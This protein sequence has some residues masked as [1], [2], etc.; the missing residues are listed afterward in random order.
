MTHAA[1]APAGPAADYGHIEPIAVYFDD[2]D[3]MGIVHNA[4]YA[5][6]LERAVTPYWTERGHYLSLIHI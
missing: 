4:R 6:L 3:A 2:L 1:L 5:V